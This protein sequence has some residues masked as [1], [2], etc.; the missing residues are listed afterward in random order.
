M[1]QALIEEGFKD[2][3]ETIAEAGTMLYVL[4][5]LVMNQADMKWFS[6][7]V[8]MYSSKKILDSMENIQ[9]FSPQDIANMLGEM[10]LKPDKKKRTRRKPPEN[11]EGE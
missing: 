4:G 7:L 9:Q 1:G 8:A 5:T 11:P 10:G 2:Y 6:E 3:D